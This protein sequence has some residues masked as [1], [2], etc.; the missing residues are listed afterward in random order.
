MHALFIVL[1]L[2]D[3]LDEILAGFVEAGVGG[4]TILDSQGMASAIADSQKVMPFLGLMK[5][6]LDDYK[7]YNK[8]IVTVLES[9]EQ[10]EAVVALVGNILG[11]DAKQGAGFMFSIPL[12]KVYKFGEQ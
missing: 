7:P 3:Y 9:E 5:N 1:N 4:A 10:V 8:T 6:F 2:T 11:D 12:A